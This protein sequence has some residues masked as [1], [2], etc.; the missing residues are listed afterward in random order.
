MW[1]PITRCRALLPAG[2]AALLL[3]AGCDSGTNETQPPPVASVAILAT[4]T[5]LSPLEAE[6]IV[7][8][9]RD[10]L[11]QPLTGRTVVWSS[12][13]PAV[14]TV[15]GTGQLVALTVGSTYLRATAEGITDSI[16]F[17]V[18]QGFF[19]LS[20]NGPTTCA[21]RA[22]SAAYCWGPGGLSGSS[23]P[24]L[25]PLP[26]LVE[27]GYH[28]ARLDLGF[29]AACGVTGGGTGYCWG[30]NH[31]GHLGNGDNTWQRQ[32]APS[33]VAGGLTWRQISAGLEHSC[34]V[35]TAGAGY[36]W[37]RNNYGEIGD[38]TQNIARY[39]PVAM[40]GGQLWQQIE[41]NGYT[42]CGLDAGGSA[43]CWG[44]NIQ[45]YLGVDS[46]I[47][48]V[49]AP[50]PLVAGG[51]YLDLDIAE[52]H[53]CAIATGGGVNCWGYNRNGELGSGVV[54]S[55]VHA[56]P[57]PLAGG[58]SFR[59]I[60]HGACGIAADST[61]WCWGPG[62]GPAPTAI[63]GGRKFVQVA[64]SCGLTPGGGAYCWSDTARVPVRL[65]DP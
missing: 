35:T 53:Q 52:V 23:T 34:G 18:A 32:Q 59:Q 26:T 49:L 29:S 38:S 36:C 33:L 42:S 24:A 5:I 58:L 63:P 27:G 44:A 25:L 19:A 41:A 15:D 48:S 51:S 46:L 64:G 30:D 10:G 1:S 57:V 40:V 21:V 37:G 11:G 20:S 13:D 31:L 6:T 4:D 55:V 8:E 2:C 16:P 56:T 9:P 50:L 60:S 3:V 45:G 54:D 65:R 47:E 39:S 62:Y 14:A 22:D 61:A 7:A 28:W 17:R 43:F 12:S